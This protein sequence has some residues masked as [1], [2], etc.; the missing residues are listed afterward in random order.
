MLGNQ[1]TIASFGA[2]AIACNLGLAGDPP[3]ERGTATQSLAADAAMLTAKPGKW[4]SDVLKITVRGGTIH[5]D[6]LGIEFNPTARSGESNAPDAQA[7]LFISSPTKGIP[8]IAEASVA[9]GDGS[10]R[11]VRLRESNGVRTIT[12]TRAVDAK[13]PNPAKRQRIYDRYYSVSFR[14]ELKN[15]VLTLKDFPTTDKVAWGVFEF[16]VPKEEITF[17]VVR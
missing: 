8:H 3:S 9:F 13:D 5:D 12:F 11:D 6:I 2:L 4:Q 15:G 10:F 7:K 16:I 1:I 17:K 14:Y